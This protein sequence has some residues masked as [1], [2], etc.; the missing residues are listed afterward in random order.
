MGDFVVGVAVVVRVFAEDVAEN[1]N[2][3]FPLLF[4]LVEREGQ[5]AHDDAN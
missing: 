5:K 2:G 4:V 3:T 1:V